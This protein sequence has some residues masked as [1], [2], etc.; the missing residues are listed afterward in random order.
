MQVTCP[1]CS[2]RYI[3]PESLLGPLGARVRCPRCREAFT[4][5]PAVPV[6]APPTEAPALGGGPAYPSDWSRRLEPEPQASAPA[7]PATERER[8]AGEDSAYRSVGPPASSS[9]ESGAE[10]AESPL[11]AADA[12]RLALDHIGP[13]AGAGIAEAWAQGQLFTRYGQA[14]VEAYEAYRRTVGP[15]ADPGL[16]RH[17]LREKWGVDLEPGAPLVR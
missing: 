13:E 1:H 17:A 5:E 7:P 14:I 4:V 6:E 2:T 3:L 16:F 11:T 9:D 8:T 10:S 15:G 12:A